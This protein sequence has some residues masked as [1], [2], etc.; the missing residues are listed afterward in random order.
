MSIYLIIKKPRLAAGPNIYSMDFRELF[1]TPVSQKALLKS[2]MNILF[3]QEHLFYLNELVSRD[4]FSQKLVSGSN[5]RKTLRPKPE[6]KF[7]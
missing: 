7:I 2:S 3:H 1:S 6:R 4:K 5:E